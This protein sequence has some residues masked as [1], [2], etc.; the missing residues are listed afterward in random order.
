VGAAE[1]DG[2]CVQSL[3]EY[4]LCRQR[5]F[6][7]YQLPLPFFPMRRL[8]TAIVLTAATVTHAAPTY[9]DDIVPIF[10]D[11]CTGCHN[12]DKLKAD[13]DLTTFAT[14][15]K[16]GSSGA[17]VKAGAADGS[18]LFRVTAHLEEPEM[19]PKKPKLA[20]TQ[21]NLIK[22]W[23]AGGALE[24]KGGVVAKSRDAALQMAVP[25]ADAK[26]EGP[27]PMPENLPPVADAA[28]IAK[29]TPVI[30][31]ASSPRAPLAAVSAHG[32]VLLYHTET[33][34]LLGALP[35]PER[36]PNVLRFSRDGALLLAAGG[37]G[38]HSGGVVVFDVKTGQRVAEAGKEVSDS[39]LAADLSPDRS[40]IATGGPDKLVRIYST[41]DGKLQRTIKK[42]TDWVTALA[43]SPDGEKLATADRNG[44]LHLWDPKTGTILY[45][46][47]EH[48]ARVTSLAWRGDSLILASAGDDG[49][50]ILWDT[51]EGWAAKSFTPADGSK[52]D[53]PGRKTMLL[54]VPGVLSAAFSAEGRI[55]TACR[56]NSLRI[57]NAN[58][59]PLATVKELPEVAT[60]TA[61]MASGQVLTGDFLGVLQIWDVKEK[62]RTV[63]TAGELGK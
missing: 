60:A 30:A 14:T 31:L 9:N 56:D 6:E 51:A 44:G 20:D 42:H 11:H 52:K 32:Q 18:L 13:L 50:L 25:A 55:V 58:G 26:V 62:E 38:A 61:F 2:V 59:G 63:V 47:A 3:S 46:L 23:I 37:R 10:K 57:F 33:K 4:D 35:F 21:I 22:E 54:K 8:A 49:K 36:Q 28:V 41:G 15:M 39:L 27:P 40:L 12:P 16:G 5:G 48:Q 53:R 45:T 19:P 29:P 34:A 43:F 1:L 24:T 17:A 7:S